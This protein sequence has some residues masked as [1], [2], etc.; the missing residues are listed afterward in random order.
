MQCK[1]C[2]A[3]IPEGEKVCP[4]CGTPVPQEENGSSEQGYT[5]DPQ[6]QDPQ[7]QNG[8]YQYQYGV[9]EPGMNQQQEGPYQYHYG[10]EQGN[11]GQ[12][13]Y[14]QM[15]YNQPNYGQSNYDQN[16]PPVNGTPY[17]V[18]SILATLLCCL[19][20]GIA[21]IVFASR[22][23]TLQ[24]M[25]DYEGA[26]AAAKKARTFTILSAVLGLVVII[27]YGIYFGFAAKDIFDTQ[28]IVE[29]SIFDESQ[30]EGAD[31]SDDEL[32]QP[33][34]DLGESWNSYTLEVNGET[35]TLP[36]SIESMEA[37]G[38]NLDTEDTGEDYIVNAGE[39][40]MVFFEDEK[41]NYLMVDLINQTED[42]QKIVDCEIGGIYVDSWETEDGSLKV[43]F[44]GGV[45]IGMSKED[46]VAA[47]GEPADV[48][49]GES[50][51]GY[52]WYDGKS[53]FKSFSAD[54]DTETG[55]VN[56][57]RIQAYEF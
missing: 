36:C 56:S 6:Q 32:I 14:G 51:Q 45:Q 52:T 5:N 50:I 28:N 46:L 39:Y 48:Y 26:R 15:N 34:G 9:N 22:I 55:R 27:G 42:P 2:R 16:R 35:I 7:Q 23:N 47:Y 37:A 21:G 30:D 10:S 13:D 17:L 54:V 31:S 57:L 29:S 12:P 1:F 44:P 41:G 40:E 25:G 43:V 11:Y 18:F 33:S 53:Y 4:V 3:D 8:Q 24:R 38:L 19:P 20:L 49:D